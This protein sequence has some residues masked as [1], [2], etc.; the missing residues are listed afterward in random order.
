[1]RQ[2]FIVCAA[3]AAL[4]VA[5][6]DIARAG[7]PEAITLEG[8]PPPS[9][10]TS[11]RLAE[12]L[13]GRG[14]G[15]RDFL[16]DGSLLVS[17]RFGDVEQVH[18]VAA[19]GAAREQLTFYAEPIGS[20]SAPHSADAAGF[21]FT[22]DRGGN[23]NAQI[24]FYRLADRSIRLLTDGRSLHGS[25]AW[26]HDGRRIAFHGTARDGASYDVYVAEVAAPAGAPPRMLVAAQAGRMWEPLAW[27]G[28]DRRL[29]LRQYVSANEAYLYVADA[30]SG[31]L[32]EVPTWPG[33]AQEIARAAGRERRA[34]RRRARAGHATRLRHA[35]AP[36]AAASAR[37]S[38]SALRASTSMAAACGWSAM[39]AASSSS[40][41]TSTSRAA[42]RA[43]SA[44]SCPGTSRTSTSAPTAATS[45]M[46][47]MSTA[48]AG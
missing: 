30:S 44:S 4:A 46:R 22:K 3:A 26:S 29:L 45:R 11:E 5:G 9:P 27:S 16:P 43:A 33:A 2:R 12:W 40:C 39:P 28:D 37:G 38:R 19:P 42:P 20:V 36:A 6:A 15:F 32:T 14:A 21:V 24:Y 31:A 8:M 18:R 48:R 13:A 17:T 25:V 47:P 41:A 1:M 7:A 34:R 10:A 35:A 23:E